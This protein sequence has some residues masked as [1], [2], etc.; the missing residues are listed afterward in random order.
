MFA[1]IAL[2]GTLLTFAFLA[3][4]AWQTGLLEPA[5]ASAQEGSKQN[6]A[7]PQ[8]SAPVVQKQ[9]VQAPASPQQFQDLEK[10]HGA[11]EPIVMTRCKVDLIE[12]EDVPS[13]REGVLMFVGIELKPDEPPP[14]GESL[15]PYKGKK[16]RRLKEG[17]RVE[18][19]Q[20]IALVEPILAEADLA[21]KVAK[22]EAAVADYTASVKT[23]DEAQRR[24]Q[25]QEQLWNSGV[26]AATTLE[27]LR[28]AQ[29]AYD[30]YVFEVHSKK[31]AIKVAEE[32]KRQAQKV[33]DMYEIRTKIAG[34]VKSINKYPGE[35]VA[36][37]SAGRN[38]E[39][40]ALIQNYDRL[41]VEGAV[42][43]QYAQ[44]LRKGMDIIIEPNYRESPEGSFSG[45]GREV[46]GLAV[47]KD[48]NNPVIVSASD[49]GTVIVWNR[50]MRYP[51]RTF[52]HPHPVTA[53]ACTPPGAQANLCLSGDHEG[54]GRIWD[55]D[56]QREKDK[57][58]ETPLVELK[59]SHRGPILCA[60]FS[61]DGKLCATGGD[62]K[63]IKVWDV[64]TG[65][66]LYTISG[67]RDH[68]E[69]L[70]FTNRGQ[71]ISESQDD[72]VRFWT[73]STTSAELTETVKRRNHDLD[74]VE[75]SRDGNLLLVEN[76]NRSEIGV[77]SLPE[78]IIRTTLRKQSGSFKKLALFS[79]DDKLVLTSESSPDSILQLWHL[80]E[81]RS[82]PTRQ[83]IPKVRSEITAAAFA[84][85][86]AFVVAGNKDGK[87]DLW[88]MPPAEELNRQVVGRIIAIEQTLEAQDKV[89]VIA[90]F[91]NSGKSPLVGAVV[92]MV[93][94]PN[95][96]AGNTAS[97]LPSRQR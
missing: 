37:A 5:L 41:S 36:A 25:T 30:R 31:A 4:V 85:N 55:L 10:P 79:P 70:Q 22:V 48:P 16:Y 87:I 26:R 94:Y 83:F 73:L 44:D 7:P 46:R 23:R 75:S 42:D 33:L 50:G 45:H 80:A 86:G 81:V 14:A 82:Q 58:E 51:S 60:V 35:A 90:E 93:A 38:S 69:H 28:G 6:A 96:Y 76:E 39:P 71:L 59:G 54:K 64:A 20:V 74:V 97:L 27:D 13:Q 62:D 88:A 65:D 56:P 32:E 61:P 49:D 95:K 1:R 67:H 57:R 91:A 66:M 47:S 17:D 84:P 11:T 8:E 29:L 15:Y 52:Y 77:M 43:V 12:K 9:V 3:G 2:V 92:N 34:I 68:V 78:K 63:E 19:N 89:R 72:T 24:L 40:I 53:V 21:I 18:A